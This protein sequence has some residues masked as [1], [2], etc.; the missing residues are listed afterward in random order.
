MLSS[1]L[2]FSCLSRLSRWLEVVGVACQR[3]V[4]WSVSRHILPGGLVGNVNE[5][6]PRLSISRQAT[7]PLTYLPSLIHNL[8]AASLVALRHASWYELRPTS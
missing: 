2:Y 3:H 7:L 5:P 8:R 4:E 1:V 6:P